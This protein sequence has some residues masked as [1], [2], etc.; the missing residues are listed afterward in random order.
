MKLFCT[1]K[2]NMIL[3][4]F[5]EN[6]IK[7]NFLNFFFYAYLE[8]TTLHQDKTFHEFRVK[9]LEWDILNPDLEINI[10]RRTSNI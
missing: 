7:T 9:T 2:K 1:L 6:E 8:I 10:M 5:D 4:E 3:K